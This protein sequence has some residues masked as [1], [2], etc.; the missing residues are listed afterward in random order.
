[1]DKIEEF[2]KNNKGCPMTPAATKQLLVKFMKFMGKEL[3]GMISEGSGGSLKVGEYIFNQENYKFEWVEELPDDYGGAT[4]D[5]EDDGIYLENYVDGNLESSITIYAAGMVI[6][7]PDDDIVFDRSG[8]NKLNFSQLTHSFNELDPTLKALCES[9]VNN[10]EVACTQEQWNVIKALLDKSL[11]FNYNGVNMIKS[12]FDGIE[13]YS[14]GSM[15]G[16]DTGFKISF[17]FISS[18]S[19]LSITYEEI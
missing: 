12:L 5:F 2:I 8:A 15:G 11:Y 14:F 6:S 17:H 10:G 16:G 3:P 1:M 9:A 4:I 13:K 7:T 18:L 19:L